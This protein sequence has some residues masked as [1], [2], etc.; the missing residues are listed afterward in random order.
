MDLDSK[1]MSHAMKGEE[2]EIAK[3]LNVKRYFWKQ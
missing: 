2:K 3:V 1:Q